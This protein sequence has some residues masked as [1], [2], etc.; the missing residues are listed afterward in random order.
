MILF[1][2]FL[3]YNSRVQRLSTVISLLFLSLT[4]NA[5]WY[6]RDQTS[7]SHILKIGPMVVSAQAA[8]I[9][10]I[11]ALIELLPAVAI[12]GLFQR[13]L[14]RGTARQG[15]FQFPW[16]VIFIAYFL[17]LCSVG[18]GCFIC[19]LYS[20]EWG[21]EKSSEWLLSMMLSVFSSAGLIQPFKVCCTVCCSNINQYLH[22]SLKTRL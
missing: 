22:K 4:T 1:V 19:I 21:Q 10:F 8:Y 9:G 5:M 13:R 7:D 15:K 17:V 18:I 11:S 3:L 20:L 14:P 6:G 2:L 16:W 12:T